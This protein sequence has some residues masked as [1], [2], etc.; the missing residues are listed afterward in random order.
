MTYSTTG[1][2]SFIP[3][4]NGRPEPASS[5]K[6]DN[7]P[8]VSVSVNCSASYSCVL[9]NCPQYFFRLL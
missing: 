9:I 7:F 2:I 5:V 3:K 4:M 1:E 8:A 6:S